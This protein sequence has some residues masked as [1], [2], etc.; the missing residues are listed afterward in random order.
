VATQKDLVQ[1]VLN[2]VKRTNLTAE[3]SASI[4]AAIR[5]YEHRRWAFNEAE[6]SF[7][8][9]ATTAVYSLPADFRGMDYVEAE[10]PGDNWQEVRPRS[11]SY[12]RK[13]LEGQSVAGYPEHYA[14]R[15]KKIHLAY[16]PNNAYHV[17]LYYKRRL[18]QMSASASNGFTNEISPLIGARASWHLAMTIMHDQPLAQMFKEVEMDEVDAAQSNHEKQVSHEKIKPYY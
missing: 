3:A 11:F 2:N 12:I 1:S 13:L 10:Y 4:V 7:T 17:K 5:H 15:D 14:L 6:H 16:Q 8:T 9:T 18:E